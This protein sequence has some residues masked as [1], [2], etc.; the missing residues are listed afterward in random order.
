VATAAA[1]GS[2]YTVGATVPITVT[3]SEAVAVTGTPKLALGDGGAAYYDP[4]EST[5]TAL[6]F[7]YTVAARQNTADLDYASTAALTLNGATIKDLAGNAAALTLPATRTDGLATQ[8]V[9]IDTTPPK[10]TSGS[11]TKAAG[12]YGVGTAIPITITFSEAVTVTGAPQLALN[13]G[14]GAAAT[15]TSGSGT[16]TLTFIYTVA[17]GQNSSDLDYSSITALTLNG[18]TVQDAAGNAAT[19]T[20]PAPGTDGL[21]A[22]HIVIRAAALTA[23]AGKIAAARLSGG[24]GALYTDLAIAQLY[25][26]DNAEKASGFDAG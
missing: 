17:A 8:H 16:S 23:T 25:G 7:D 22:R 4:N 18:A 15:Y 14:G 24:A 1:A 6:T 26:T 2:R 11:S 13:A 19:L 9:V 12:T 20:L 3:F 10:V 5:S 21:A